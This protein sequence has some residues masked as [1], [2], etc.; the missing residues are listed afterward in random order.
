MSK[1]DKIEVTVQMIAV[2]I[3]ASATG[4]GVLWFSCNL[5]FNPAWAK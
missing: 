2:L 3:A 5:L 4:Y 1:R